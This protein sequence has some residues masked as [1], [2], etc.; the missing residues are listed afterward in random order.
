MQAGAI[1]SFGINTQAPGS[2]RSE[3][4]KPQALSRNCWGQLGDLTLA[5]PHALGPKEDSEG[6]DFGGV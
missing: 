5:P 1:Q 3:P 4:P 2:C 6:Q